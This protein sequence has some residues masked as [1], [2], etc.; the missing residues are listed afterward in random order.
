M[1]LKALALSRQMQ[2]A[3][4]CSPTFKTFNRPA[5]RAFPKTSVCR[6][7]AALVPKA[8]RPATFRF[9]PDSDCVVGLS[10]EIGPKQLLVQAHSYLLRRTVQIAQMLEEK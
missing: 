8:K 9:F 2:V 6:L 1:T 3:P 10:P 7:T 5:L 4:I